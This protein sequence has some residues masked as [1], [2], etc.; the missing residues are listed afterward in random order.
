M[1]KEILNQLYDEFT[2]TLQ[3][4]GVSDRTPV[5]G[6]GHVHAKIMLIGEAPGETEE[7]LGQPF[8]GK[9]GKNLD[10]FLD[11]IGLNREDIFITNAVKFRPVKPGKRAG[12]FVNRAPDKNELKL[13]SELL[14]KELSIIQPDYIVT[15]GNI[16]LKAVTGEKS[17]SIGSVH[18]CLMDINVDDMPFKLF[19]LYHPASVIYRRE[20]LDVYLADIA[21]LALIVK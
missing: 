19:P 7:K 4:S 21:K 18:G 11:S 9:A 10:Q 15:L 12:S 5:Y 16:P 17:I 6:I 8:V 13:C 20:L 3:T 1:P 14:V 2:K